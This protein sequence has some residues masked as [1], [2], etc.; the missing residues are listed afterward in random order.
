[1]WTEIKEWILERSCK[2]MALAGFLLYVTAFI[3]KYSFDLAID[4][5]YIF[6]PIFLM[7]GLWGYSAWRLHCYPKG[8]KHRYK[9]YYLIMVLSSSILLSLIVQITR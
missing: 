5:V 4:S 7:L 9:S 3:M 6:I 2:T 8:A 1:M